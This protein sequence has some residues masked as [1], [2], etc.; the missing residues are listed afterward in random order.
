MKKAIILS[1]ALSLIFLSCK[2]EKTEDPPSG[3]TETPLKTAV[4]AKTPADTIYSQANSPANFGFKF[5]SNT[6]GTIRK[7][8]CRMPAA[9]NYTVT[10][11]DFAT[12]AS[13]AQTTVTVTDA[14]QFAYSAIT[15]VVAISE[16]TRYVISVNNTI[17]GVGKPYFQLFKKPNTAI[18]IYPFTKG[19]ITI[20]APLYKGGA[21]P[22]MPNQNNA[23]DFPFMRGVADLEIDFL[24]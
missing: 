23:S 8:G 1:L 5:Y 14:G 3:N 10:L 9:G 12:G 21:T 20:E 6:A 7:L 22:V 4:E 2:K 19:R 17:G 18:N 13:L 24:M 16:N 15:P 11:W